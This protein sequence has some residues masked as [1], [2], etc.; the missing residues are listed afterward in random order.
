MTL[1]KQGN[2]TFNHVDQQDDLYKV[3][4]ALEIKTD[5]DSR[6]S[7]LKTTLNNLVDA[8]TAITDSNSG[9]D[10]IKATPIGTSPDTIQGI[11]EW[12]KNQQDSV[13]LGQISDGSITKVKLAP[14]VTAQLIDYATTTGT[15]N[16]YVVTLNPAPAA[17]TDGMAISVKINADATAASTLNANSLGAKSLK[18]SNGTDVTNLKTNG[19]YTFRYNST[20]GNFILQGEGGSGTA[21]APDVLAGKTASTDTGDITGTMTDR[22]AMTITPGTTDQI[23][24]TGFH[25]GSGKVVGDLDLIPANVRALVNIYGVVG[26]CFATQG[27]TLASN[28][29]TVRTT[30]STTNVKLKETRADHG[31]SYRV[32][33]QMYSDQVTYTV[34]AQIYVNGVVRGIARSTNSISVVTF[35]EDIVVNSGDLIQIYASAPSGNLLTIYKLT[36]SILSPTFGL[37][38]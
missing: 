9:A 20:T 13:V 2:F 3:Q 8:L 12:L 23:I 11:L 14:A 38:L 19:V 15:A 6:A 33:F 7:E 34:N 29:T 31:G 26:Q 22:G 16:A 28:N 25:N 27:D 37:I 36:L 18:K 21:T 10:N 5:F 35:T 24:P 1:P 17:Y 32:A 30:S 4:S